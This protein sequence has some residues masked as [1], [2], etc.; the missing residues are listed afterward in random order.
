[1]RRAVEQHWPSLLAGS[2][3]AGLAAS[4]VLS[5]PVL[6]LAL[7]GLAALV[8]VATLVGGARTAALAAALAVGGLWWGGLRLE[9]LGASV[10]EGKL[11]ES[12]SA[13]LVVTGPARTSPWAVRVQARVTR[14]GEAR[15][16]E[17]VL[18]V[19]PVGR[20]PPRGAILE[21]VARVFEPRE[22]EGGFDER[23]WLSRQGIHVVLR[24]GTWRQ[25][26]ARGGLGGL[27][28]RLRD[29]VEHAVERGASGVQRAL[30]LG[31]VLGEDEGLPERV[32]EDFRASGLYHLLAVS[33]QN[34]AFLAL[35]IYGLGWLL[36]L[37]RVARELATV[38]GI[39]LYVLAVGWQPSVVRA[40]VAG[41]LAS[42]AWLAARPRDRW[43][44]FALGALVLLVWAPT[45]VL[46]PGFQLSFAAVAAI[47]VG[48]PRVR[49]RLQGYPVPT[50]LAEG[51]GVATVCGLVTAP[52]VLFH[53]GEAPLYTVPANVLAEPAVPIVLG[54]GLLAGVV[55]PVSPGVA[56]AL[57]WL[58]GW[59]AAW[60]EL[61]ARLVASLPSAQIGATTALALAA[62]L[63]LAWLA[64]RHTARR[65]GARGAAVALG[66][67]GIAGVVVVA[68]WSTL[69]PAPVWDRPA[70]MRVTFLDVGQGD[71]VLLE[72]PSARVL[73]DQGPPEADV[74]G[75]L[76]RMGVRSLSALVLTHPQRDHVGGAADVIRQLRVGAVLDPGLAATGPEREEAVAAARERRVAL[77]VVRA[78][79]E[80]KAGGLVL[81][82]LWPPDAG[83]PAEDPNLNALVL[84][85]TYGETDVLLTADAESDVTARLPLR[86]VELM[87]V[88]HHG[89]T[90]PGLDDELR[91]VRPRV[92]VISCG[93]NN[94]Y[95]HPRPETLA[96][97]AASP[98]LAVYRTD[99]DGRVVV[100]SDGRQLRV[101]TH[102]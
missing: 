16:Q 9:A 39:G 75:Q 63:A 64:L 80:F 72:T 61:V 102:G 55:D 59:P 43:H 52:I 94:D 48:V 44:F 5:A 54:I 26:G 40:G 88:A 78:G 18:L 69:R 8:A 17:R 96:A 70:G 29:R 13:E 30:V 51:L 76:T 95:G 35:G 66:L 65:S 20:S 27:G 90:D 7:L 31:V 37:P 32:R 22:A 33:G 4:N 91:I 92:A 25:I 93:R 101:R 11:G 50:R 45:A 10:L 46:E 56:A 28:D 23:A 41:A 14:F 34:V 99:L 71:S 60:L 12:A 42:L 67:A 86:E 3:C 83:S 21:T 85:A 58:A 36:R 47:F 53:F 84:V 38:G 57:A 77:Q 82:V 100:E 81:R 24:T 19:L 87:K 1:V 68:G 74:A 79:S 49:A 15:L 73:V 62:A 6:V 97:L 89:S 2:A 98:G